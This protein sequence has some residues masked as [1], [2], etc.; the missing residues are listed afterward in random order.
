MD[1]T[2]NADGFA[3]LEMFKDFDPV[4]IDSSRHEGRAESLLSC[5]RGMR[6]VLAADVED[7][8]VAARGRSGPDP[9]RQSRICRRL[10]AM[11]IVLLSCGRQRELR[12]RALE[13]GSLEKELEVIEGRVELTEGLKRVKTFKV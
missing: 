12:S 5:L 13:F 6:D 11:R 1:D 8:A 3:D 2:Y 4:Q 9:M 7:E 10:V